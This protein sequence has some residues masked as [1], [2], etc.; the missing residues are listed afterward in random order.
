MY[1]GEIGGVTNAGTQQEFE[2]V[3]DALQSGASPFTSVPTL[4][5]QHSADLVTVLVNNPAS[6]ER[7]GL[8]YVLDQNSTTLSNTTAFSVIGDNCATGDYTFAHEVGHNLSGRHDWGAGGDL[9]DNAPFHFNHG[10]SNTLSGLRT[11]MSNRSLSGGNDCTNLATDPDGCPRL[12][13]WANPNQ[14]ALFNGNQETL[15]RGEPS[16]TDMVQAIGLTAPTVAQFRAVSGSAPGAPTSFLVAPVCG[17]YNDLVWSG[18][19]GNVGW[20]E[21]YSSANTSY[22][23]QYL[24]YRGGS[25]TMGFNVAS[26]TY[27]R[28]RACN[29]VGCSAYR[30]GSAPATTACP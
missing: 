22:S 29:A 8:A 16:P 14:T 7:C 3:R 18:A 25:S 11:L 28:V 27:L 10:F 1:Y 2:A 23:P 4:R 30:N 24:A 6:S 26:T 5:N 21:L 19:S 17:G 20:Y 12:N 13:R 15:G 9:T